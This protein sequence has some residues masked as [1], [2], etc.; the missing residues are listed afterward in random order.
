MTACA[1]LCVVSTGLLVKTD[2][3]VINQR[4][5][6]FFAKG[7]PPHAAALCSCA[8]GGSAGHFLGSDSEVTDNHKCE[9]KGKGKT[10]K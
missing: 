4:N 5:P 9:V 7:F 8:E 1:T 3:G 2:D 6:V 10:R